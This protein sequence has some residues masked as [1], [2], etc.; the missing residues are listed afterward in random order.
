MPDW[1]LGGLAALGD[2]GLERA[3]VAR[4]ANVGESCFADDCGANPAL[5]VEVRALRRTEGWCVFLLLTPWM[6]ARVFLPERVPDLAV[7]AGWQASARGDADYVVIGPAV[8]VRLLGGPQRAHLNHDPVL[9]HYLIQPLVQ[10]MDKF[11]GPD[12]VFRAWNDVIATRQR[13]MEEQQRDCPWQRELSRREFF[14]RLSGSARR[15]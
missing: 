11:D 12:A 9:G 14:A 13:V 8:E 4:F 1:Q 3:V 6:L 7:P 5:G 10:A 15:G 2:E